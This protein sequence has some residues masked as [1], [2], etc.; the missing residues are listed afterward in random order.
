MEYNRINDKIIIEQRYIG[1][2]YLTRMI[3]IWLLYDKLKLPIQT[4]KN[5]R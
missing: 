1:I 2:D 3:D 4:L 5:E